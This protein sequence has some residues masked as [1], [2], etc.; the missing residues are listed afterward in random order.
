VGAIMVLVEQ[1]TKIMD[2]VPLMSGT[3]PDYGYPI[4][5]LTFMIAFSALC[6]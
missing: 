2:C 4:T 5:F 6:V 3:S 1:A